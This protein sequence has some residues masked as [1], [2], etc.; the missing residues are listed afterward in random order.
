MSTISAAIDKFLSSGWGKTTHL[1]TQAR[2]HT[3]AHTHFGSA[4][5]LL[6][7]CQRPTPVNGNKSLWPAVLS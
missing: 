3:R 7:A 4:V 1:R 5:L 2:M 6:L